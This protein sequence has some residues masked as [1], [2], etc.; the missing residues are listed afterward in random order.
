M[1]HRQTARIAAAVATVALTTSVAQAGGLP[2]IDAGSDIP[3]PAYVGLS[4]QQGMPVYTHGTATGGGSTGFDWTLAGSTV[5]GA[6]VLA[7]LGSALVVRRSRLA[8][9]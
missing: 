6:L 7:G 1:N 8:Q 3:N 4:P 2:P 9:A 5:G